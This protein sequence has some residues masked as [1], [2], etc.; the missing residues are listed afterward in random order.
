ME[1]IL[2]GACAETVEL[3]AVESVCQVVDGG[4]RLCCS[5]VFP[6][7]LPSSPVCVT[8]STSLCVPV[9]VI[10]SQSLVSPSRP[11]VSVK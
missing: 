3:L 4:E 7:P 8:L 5:L 2:A 9:C 1:R 11:W 6:Q 10:A